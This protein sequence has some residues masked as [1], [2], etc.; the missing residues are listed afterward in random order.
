MLKEGAAVPSAPESASQQLVLDG[1]SWRT[2]GRLLRA[3][4]DRHLRLTYDRGDLEIMTLSPE[5]E[6]FKHLLGL[7]IGVLVEELGWDMAGFGSMTFKSSKQ[8]R[9]LE[10]DECYWIQSES[11]VR[12]KDTIDVRSDPAPDLVFE[13]DVTHS[14]LDRLSIYAAMGV[15][16]VWRFDGRQLVAHLLGP[17]GRYLDSG[18][19]RAFPFLAL[20]EIE[21]FLGTRSAHSETELVRR[22]RDW[23]R[24]RIATGW[25]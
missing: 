7:L 10:P 9:G 6:R 11:L 18:Q 21:R 24:G 22:F 5:H 8:R 20:A 14:S 25:Q 4:D 19:S 16:E 13:V 2:Y 17:E 1:V 3:F 12:G 15:P 23:V